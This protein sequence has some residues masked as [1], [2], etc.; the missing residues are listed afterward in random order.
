MSNSIEPPVLMSRLLTFVFATSLVVVIV[1]A[2]TLIKMYPLEKTQL[3]FLTTQPKN[4]L[5]IQLSDYTP[6]SENI[7]IYKQAFIKEYIKARNEIIPNAM[8]MRKKWDTT[9]DGTVYTWSTPEV[10]QAFQNTMMWNAYMSEP[11]DF[12]FYCPVEF[13]GIAPRARNKETNAINTYA[14]SFRYFCTNSNGQ[15]DDKDST[16][17]LNKDYT[18]VVRLAPEKTIKW[19]DRLQNPLGLRVAEYTVE[20][21]GGDPLD[22]R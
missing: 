20:S 14:I 22:F 1:L 16:I 15:G 5:V 19:T 7:E 3:F 18:I 13:T 17:V 6:N 9:P 8:V 11:P 21:G 10:Y 12:F 4:D 2:V